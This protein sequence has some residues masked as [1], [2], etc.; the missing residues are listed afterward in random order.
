MQ[1]MY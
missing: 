1:V